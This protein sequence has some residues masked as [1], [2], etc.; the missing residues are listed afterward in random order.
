MGLEETGPEG[1]GGCEAGA[2]LRCDGTNLIRCNADGTAEVSEPCALG[3]NSAALRC[4]DVSNGLGKFFAMADGQPEFNLGESA[5][6]NTDTGDVIV[7]GSSA[8]RLHSENMTQS[9]GP[10]V[11]VFVV[12]SLVAKDVTISGKNAFALVSSGDIKING[13]FAASA[14]LGTLANPAA[15]GPG[16]FSDDSC[17]GK[18][19]PASQTFNCRGGSGGGGFGSPGGAGGSA[20]NSYGFEAGGHGGTIAGNPEL[21]PLRGGCAG[22]GFD[23]TA[24]GAIQLISRTQ[25]IASGFVAANGGPGGGSGGGILLEAPS[26]DVAG[27]VVANG[28]GGGDGEAGRLDAVPAMGGAPGGFGP[29]AKGGAGN[30]AA[31]PGPNI[32]VRPNGYFIRGISGGGGVGRI[33]VNTAPGGLRGS[34]VFSPPPSQGVFA[35]Q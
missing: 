34:G 2:A 33:R 25:I 24:G 28:A 12:K 20:Q 21:V 8:P 35:S 9:N 15:A 30:F 5:T 7:G 16:A 11:R 26:I 27:G 29:G 18:A 31:M 19:A 10:V 4:G 1:G 22:G 17:R 14:R 23:E 32:D 13:V 6:I 3:C